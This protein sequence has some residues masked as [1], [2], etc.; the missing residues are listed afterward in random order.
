V[1][2]LSAV[3]PSTSAIHDQPARPSDG[4][5]GCQELTRGGSYSVPF[6]RAFPQV[7]ALRR[8]REHCKNP[9]AAGQ[10]VWV[11]ARQWGSVEMTARD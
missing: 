3:L 4:A 10:A 1:Y 7:T 8:R 6:A 5:S 11:D 2:R 9:N